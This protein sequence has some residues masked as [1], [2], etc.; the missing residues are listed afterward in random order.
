VNPLTAR[1]ASDVAAP[2]HAAS[3]RPATAYLTWVLP[4]VVTAALG[5][6]EIGVPQ[7]W[8]DE[9]ASWSAASRTVPQLWAM[10]HN[11]DAVL[12]FYYFGLHF[13]M[14]LFGD[15]PTAMRLPSVI[16][17]TG[18][19]VVVAL[20][21]RRLGGDRA[22]LASGLVFAL[23]P[24]VSRY[25][26]EARP[27][28]FAT[29]F[30]ALA[31]LTFLRAFERPR[32]SRWAIY[33]VMVAAA[34]AANLIAVCVVAAHLA[35]VLWDF[36]Q[37]TVRVGGDGAEDDGKALPGGRLD[38]DGSPLLLLR[39]FCVAAVAGAIL[40]S[41]LVIQGH[42]QQGWQIGQQPTPHVAQLIGISGGLWQE[43]F[44]SIPVAAVVLLLGV[45]ALV[46]GADSRHR[47]IAGY[48]LALAIVPVIAVWFISRGPTSYWTFR[49]MLFSVTG[50]AVAAGLGIT[51]LTDRARAGRLGRLSG[52]LSH[53][54]AVAA[55][56]VVVVGL[57][58]I[59]DQLAIRQNVAHNLWAYPEQPPN[60]TAVD[61][62][63]A[64]RVIEKRA[65]P[66]DVI[67]YQ[68]S[69]QNHY[70]VDTSLK[71]Y[72]KG[73]KDK[74]APVFQAQTQIESQSLQ[75]VQCVDPSACMSGTPRIWVVYVDHLASDPFSAL[76]GNEA[77]LLQVLGYYQ[78]TQWQENGISVA[79]LTA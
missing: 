57:A 7:L 22:G 8:R 39:R 20:I 58:G 15:S 16:A 67:A 19:A 35:I 75:P 4:G 59:H 47:V 11:I 60:G 46:A 77:A 5:L 10:L 53:R 78:A 50:W 45:A 64:A 41:P 38:P 30:A 3:P 70:Q 48:A 61:Y 37:R 43:L 51:Y 23:I 65:K 2:E 66:G 34:G 56:L 18:A 26:Q 31:T 79:L 76:P 17:M 74:P 12:G 25:A 40:V 63:A 9:F 72:L 44:S 27:Y 54:F 69:D 68:V 73:M 42:T 6:F 32:W 49:Y 36:C 13:W 14:A 33:A 55:G 71:Y 24:S 28:A 62:K 21:G 1:R 52:L 29:L